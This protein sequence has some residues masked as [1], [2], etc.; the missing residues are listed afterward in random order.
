MLQLP[1]HYTQDATKTDTVQ[2]IPIRALQLHEYRTG[3]EGSSPGLLGVRFCRWCNKGPPK[4]P[5]AC[6]VHH[7]PESCLRGRCNLGMER[8][9]VPG[10]PRRP[11]VVLV[12][13]RDGGGVVVLEQVRLGVEAPEEEEAGDGG[14]EEDEYHPQ[15]AHLCPEQ[16]TEDR[17]GIKSSKA[18]PFA[19][20]VGVARMGGD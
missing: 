2:I 15:R 13:R 14:G 3:D 4:V 17:T 6:H 12:V 19:P 20:L 10:R 11:L 9:G 7:R 8:R 18:P 16:S 5:P 1:P